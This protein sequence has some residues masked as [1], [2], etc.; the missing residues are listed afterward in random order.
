MRRE[1]IGEIV[2]MVVIIGLFSGCTE[3]EA[4]NPEVESTIIGWDIVSNASMYHLKISNLH[5]D[6]FFNVSDINVYNYPEQVEI[7]DG[8]M[9]FTPYLGQRISTPFHYSVRSYVMEK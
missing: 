3:K 1:I 8:G 7:R 6:V 4:F 5:G 2:L 9:Y